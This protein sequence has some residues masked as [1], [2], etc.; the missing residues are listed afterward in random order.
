MQIFRS[1]MCALNPNPPPRSFNPYSCATILIV[2]F[3]FFSFFHCFC[4]FLAAFLFFYSVLFFFSLPFFLLLT[5][6]PV[7]KATE[8]PSNRSCRTLDLWPEF[9]Y[10][11]QTDGAVPPLHTAP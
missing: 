6:P 4:S 2:M 5:L 11:T 7:S 10:S 3:L 9:E 8:R 1:E